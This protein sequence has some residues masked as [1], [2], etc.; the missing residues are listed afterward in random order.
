MIPC[1][2]KK[3]KIVLAANNQLDWLNYF[4]GHLGCSSPPII[5]TSSLL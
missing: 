2:I 4:D 1:C 3:Y 5:F